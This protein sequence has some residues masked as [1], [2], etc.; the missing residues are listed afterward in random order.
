MGGDS[1]ESGLVRFS[2]GLWNDRENDHLSKQRG[3]GSARSE[4][5]E[6][7]GSGVAALLADAGGQFLHAAEADL[8]RCL[9]PVDAFGFGS[10]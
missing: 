3:P 2:C 4:P 5:V 7:A 8:G 9:V 1:G 6:I 10:G